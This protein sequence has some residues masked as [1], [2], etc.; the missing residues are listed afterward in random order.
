MV[1]DL[2]GTFQGLY[3]CT[4]MFNTERFKKERYCVVFNG[5]Y[6][7]NWFRET[8]SLKTRDKEMT[9]AGPTC[10]TIVLN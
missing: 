6:Q 8:F 9:A 4:Y 2:S 3:Q 5:W 10:V 7:K 1:A